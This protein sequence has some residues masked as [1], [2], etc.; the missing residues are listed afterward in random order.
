MN[1]QSKMDS[2]LDPTLVDSL[3][4]EHQKRGES[5]KGSNQRSEHRHIYRNQSGMVVTVFNSKSDV[6]RHAVETLDLSEHGTAFL[7]SNFLHNGTKCVASL[8]SIA[9]KWTH[10]V[11]Y[12]VRCQLLEANAHEVAIHFQSKIDPT[13]FTTGNA[14]TETPPRPQIPKLVGRVLYVDDCVDDRDLMRFQLERIGVKAMMASNAKEALDM[15]DAKI[16][17]DLLITDH[18]PMGVDGL[19]LIRTLR[20]KDNDLPILLI[21]IDDTVDVRDKAKAMGSYLER[22]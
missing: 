13:Q 20:D 14:E 12:V 6:V 10:I 16:P 11:G 5:H 15:L 7:H 22:P 4:D 17:V 8:E 21:T 1:G 9:G 3:Q 2:G 19:E 18:H